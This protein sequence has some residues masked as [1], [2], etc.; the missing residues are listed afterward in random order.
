MQKRH[1]QE[2]KNQLLQLLEDLPS[3]PDITTIRYN[4]NNAQERIVN[5]L[6]ISSKE[7]TSKT[8]KK[9]SKKTTAMKW[10]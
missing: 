2:L 10:N 1:L 8:M 7:Y 4:L 9:M 6:E 3:R 5:S